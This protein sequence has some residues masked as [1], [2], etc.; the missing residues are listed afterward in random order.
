MLCRSS[1]G[2]RASQPWRTPC[3]SSRHASLPITVAPVPA[4]TPSR[5][6]L[7]ARGTNKKIWPHPDGSVHAIQAK[8][9]MD[10]VHSLV[11]NL[12]PHSAHLGERSPAALPLATASG[13]VLA[14]AAN[15]AVAA[16]V[17]SAS[18]RCVG[19]GPCHVHYMA[20][21]ST[22]G[23]KKMLFWVRTFLWGI[24]FKQI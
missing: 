8:A 11:S 24:A 22:A 10:V 19:T 20:S 17:S 12:D 4:C 16:P 2:M 7:I 14:A 9:A 3:A 1:L 6:Q 18:Q 21:C 5:K 13:T 23:G 15:P